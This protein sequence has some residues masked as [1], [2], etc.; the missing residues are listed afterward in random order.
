MRTDSIETVIYISEAISDEKMHK[1][2][3][4]LD[5]DLELE[6][7]F[8]IHTRNPE[9]TNPISEIINKYVNNEKYIGKNEI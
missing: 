8:L 4:F 6:E 5:E 1:L 9:V 3:A 2:I 7:T